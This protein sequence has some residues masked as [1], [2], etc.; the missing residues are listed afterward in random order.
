VLCQDESAALGIQIGTYISWGYGLSRTEYDEYYGEVLNNIPHGLGVKFYSDGSIYKGDFKNGLPHTHEGGSL[1]RPNGFVYEGGWLNGKK[2][3][4]GSIRYPQIERRAVYEGQFANGFEHGQGILKYSDDSIHKGRFR[5]GVRDGPG[6]FT[7]VAGNV[8]KGNFKDNPSDAFNDIPP[9][10]IVEDETG[11]LLL[12][13]SNLLEI[14]LKAFAKHAAAIPRPAAM[15]PL[16]LQIKM[17]RLIS[18]PSQ[19]FQLIKQLMVMEFY[20]ALHHQ[21]SKVRVSVSPFQAYLSTG[22][23]IC[24]DIHVCNVS[25]TG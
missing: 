5:F 6:S 2:H 8:V 14:A 11:R 22:E 1:M 4:Y 24:S 16:E 13:P 18:F 21:S 7:D 9:P 10:R 23:Y 19:N 15:E 17:S 3:G 20:N 25:I 12:N